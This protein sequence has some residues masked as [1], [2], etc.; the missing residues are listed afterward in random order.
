M[1]S[2]TI[3]VGDGITSLKQFSIVLPLSNRR[4]S[5][6]PVPT[7]TV[8]ILMV[9]GMI[10]APE[11]GTFSTSYGAWTHSG[12]L[13]T[14]AQEVLVAPHSLVVAAP[15]RRQPAGIDICSEYTLYYK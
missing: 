5:C 10:S 12:T 15:L 1:R 6:V 2:A 8:S 9:S 14:I 3:T 11:F 13:P 7:S 4:I